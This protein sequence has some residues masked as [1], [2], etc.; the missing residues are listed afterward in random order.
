MATTTYNSAVISYNHRDTLAENPACRPS[1]MLI[2]PDSF[3]GGLE[4]EL[5]NL[6]EQGYVIHDVTLET[7]CAACNGAGRRAKTRK[8]RGRN[9][10]TVT[11]TVPFTFIACPDC[12][13]HDGPLASAKAA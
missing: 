6:R 4:G 5:A 11:K 3:D 9:G 8:V 12:K 13:G 1:M 2:N 10:Q 7:I